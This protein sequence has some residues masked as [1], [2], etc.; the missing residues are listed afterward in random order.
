LSAPWVS[1]IHARV[2]TEFISSAGLDENKFPKPTAHSQAPRERRPPLNP[3]NLLAING[4]MKLPA[5]HDSPF[6]QL[7]SA[8]A[9]R[10][11]R[12]VAAAGAEHLLHPASRQILARLRAA[13]FADWQASGGDFLRNSAPTAA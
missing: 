5:L 11:L 3:I 9:R 12:F 13:E 7:A 6:V 1:G 10:N 2:Q 8:R 4:R